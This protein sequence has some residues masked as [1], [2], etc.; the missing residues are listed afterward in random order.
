MTVIHAGL[1]G[2]VL[3]PPFTLSGAESFA[4]LG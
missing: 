1:C 2:A 3:L 4:L